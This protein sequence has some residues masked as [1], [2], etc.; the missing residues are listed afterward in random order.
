MGYRL[1]VLRI[2]DGQAIRNTNRGDSRESIRRKKIYS[3]ITFVAIRANG[4]KPAIR[5]F[6][7]PQIA[8][9]KKGVQFGTLKRFARIRPS[10]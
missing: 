1:V 10:K 4:L 2:V 9:R 7:V 5:K 6:L 8:I 3:F